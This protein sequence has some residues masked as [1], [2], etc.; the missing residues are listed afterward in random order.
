[1]QTQLLN[2]AIANSGKGNND[3]GNDENDG[4]KEP[5]KIDNKKWMDVLLKNDTDRMKEQI[6]ILKKN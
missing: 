1:M 2:W 5:S 4:N 3:Q 6:A